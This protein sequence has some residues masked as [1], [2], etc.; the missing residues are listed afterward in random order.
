MLRTKSFP[1]LKGGESCMGG[2][3]NVQKIKGDNNGT[4]N[5]R[6][7]ITPDFML[8]TKS[9]P[10]FKRRGKLPGMAN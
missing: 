10:S 3:I 6:R 9:L 8:R 1:S 4:K 2:P 7:L 5:K